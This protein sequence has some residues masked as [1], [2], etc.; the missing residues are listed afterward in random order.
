MVNVS[1]N[2][3]H[4]QVVWSHCLK[5]LLTHSRA[6]GRVGCYIQYLTPTC[7]HPSKLVIALDKER[8]S[9][10][11]NCKWG[12][13]HTVHSLIL[14]YFT[15]LIRAIYTLFFVVWHRRYSF[16]LYCKCIS[17][18]IWRIYVRILSFHLT[19]HIQADWPLWTLKI[20]LQYIRLYHQE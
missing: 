6:W 7:L 4:H 10:S 11:Q 13:T 14:K 17:K 3:P 15:S 1:W 2:S 20:I 8:I 12:S 19:L 16:H 9:V 18:L 5:E